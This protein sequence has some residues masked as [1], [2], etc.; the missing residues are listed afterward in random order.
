MKAVSRLPGAVLFVCTYNRV[1]SPMAAG[2]VRRLYGDAVRVESCGLE[3]GGEVDP[4]AAAV[5]AEI[6]VD[7]SAHQSRRF[8]ALKDEGFDL[9]IALCEG[10]WPSVSAAAGPAAQAECWPTEDP[11]QGEGSRETRL[12]AY[13]LMRRALERRITDRFG[14]PAEWE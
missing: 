10:A 8:D 9:L 14:L 1:R 7:L 6:G 4:L 12:E 11:T 2:L 5:M 13:R 3:P